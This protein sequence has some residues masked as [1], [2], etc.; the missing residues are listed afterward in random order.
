MSCGSFGISDTH[1]QSPDDRPRV[2]AT[3]RAREKD[4]LSRR[5]R[6]E[7]SVGCSRIWYIKMRQS[8]PDLQAAPMVEAVKLYCYS[9]DRYGKS[10]YIYPMYG[11]GG[12][13]LTASCSNFPD[14]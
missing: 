6:V 3:E 12:L 8:R 1:V 5:A 7:S 4:A 14:L 10:P 9:L 13:F 11:L 2:A